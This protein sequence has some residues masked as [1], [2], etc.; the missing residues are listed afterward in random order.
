[1]GKRILLVNDLPGYGKVALSAMMPVLGHMGYSLHNLP[2]ALVSNT[3]DYGLFS[4][5]ET[6]EYM[7]DCIRVWGEL[8]FSF[9]A[10]ATGFIVTGEQAKLLAAYCAEQ[11][12]KGTLIFTD[13]IMGDE[14]KLY[15]GITEETVGHMRTLCAEADYVVPNYTEAAFLTG[16]PCTSEPLSETEV[17]SLLDGMRAVGSRS[18]VIT[19]LSTEGGA[20]V[21]GYDAKTDSYF[22]IPYEAIPIRFPGTGDV[23][24][25]L[26]TGHMLRGTAMSESVRK[27][28]TGVYRLI[29]RNLDEPDTYRGL[30]IESS[31][32]LIDC[33]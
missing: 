4:I 28:M 15:N 25:A 12:E 23:F 6:T 32:A 5:K 33:D 8:G 3:L 17:R 21:A 2:T 9:D 18:V 27:S 20:A 26:F 11:R 22:T 7:K 1:M 29:E 24:S 31:L 19:S 14:G 16:T 30:P 10:I 13:P